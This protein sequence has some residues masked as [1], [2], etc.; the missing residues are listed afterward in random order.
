M[1]FPSSIG[2]IAAEI[3]LIVFLLLL[4]SWIFKIVTNS[5]DKKAMQLLVRQ[6]KESKADREQAIREGLQ[7]MSG[8]SGEKLETTTLSILREE[9][10]LYNQFVDLYRRRDAQLAG[11]FNLIVEDM[12]TPY[13][14]VVC[15]GGSG[16]SEDNPGLEDN[17]E[18][19][20][21]LREANQQLQEELR[22]T[23]ETMA[24]M[25]KDYSS[26]LVDEEEGSTAPIEDVEDVED[27]EIIDEAAEVETVVDE[28]ESIDDLGL[29]DIDIKIEEV[30]IDVELSTD[31]IDIEE[32]ELAE[33][34]SSE[35]DIS[36]VEDIADM[37]IDDFDIDDVLFDV[38]TDEEKK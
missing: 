17:S 35:M 14:Q 23:T 29:D 21:K 22:I 12:L 38:G 34:E 27:I 1:S 33:Q 28:T 6:V 37:D 26:N 31:D 24:T 18:A 13:Y 5:R 25:L 32:P 3:A 16:V 9:M 10:R 20:N 4:I 19:I 30:D 2:L 11:Q 8:I 15:E 36:E 7:Q